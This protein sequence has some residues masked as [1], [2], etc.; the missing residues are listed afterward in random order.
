MSEN[1]GPWLGGQPMRR[2]WNA[3]AEL[4]PKDFS[5]FVLPQNLNQLMDGTNAHT[6]RTYDEFIRFIEPVAPPTPERKRSVVATSR[7]ML[8]AIC[9][10]LA[11]VITP[12]GIAMSGAGVIATGVGFAAAAVIFGLVAIGQQMIYSSAQKRQLPPQQRLAQ[13]F[14]GEPAAVLPVF[15]VDRLTM[16]A[17]E[18]DVLDQCLGLYNYCQANGLPLSADHWRDLTQHA[19]AQT[20]LARNTDQPKGLE[21]L[22]SN[23]ERLDL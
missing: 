1:I 6:F 9:M 11:M 4:F 14:G 22:R 23:I 13:K 17:E 5:R 8:A 7:F 20:R 10:V 2:E 3:S 21:N 16:T 18:N 19:L 12:I 15:I